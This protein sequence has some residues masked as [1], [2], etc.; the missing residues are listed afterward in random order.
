MQKR[1]WRYHYIPEMLLKHFT[2]CDGLLH[3]VDCAS[4]VRRPPT[5]PREIG[6]GR[7]FYRDEESVD[8]D[9]IEGALKKIENDA[10]HVLQRVMDTRS[11]PT[12]SEDWLPLI[13]FVA[14]Q[15]VRVPATKAMIARPIHRE[16]EIVA[17]L[18]MSN[19]GLYKN[20]AHLLA[21]DSSQTSY[22]EFLAMDEKSLI[23]ELSVGEFFEYALAMMKPIME[24][25]NVRCWNVVHSDKPG[26]HFVISDDPVVL[27]WS[28]GKPRRLPPGYAH[29]NSDVT[30]PIS[31]SI[32]LLAT[33]NDFVVTPES[34]RHHVARIN[35]KTIAAADH[36]VAAKSDS[37]LC[38]GPDG[39]IE[40][41]SLV[42]TSIPP[43]G[44]F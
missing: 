12:T 33:H 11:H 15:A 5:I 35:S 41:T 1:Q 19:P 27:Y 23:P 20:S 44:G 18:L 3:Y 42:V 7:D 2:D 38:Y 4:N 40:G 30:I 28:D 36:F 24:S 22:K 31:S 34:I 39:V 43:L 6:Y 14:I 25:L 21:I 29:I 37:F 9:V 26:E 8:P 32:A 10:A 13:T 16:H 17:D